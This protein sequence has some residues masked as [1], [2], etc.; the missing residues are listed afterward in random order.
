MPE[1]NESG[2]KDDE[3]KGESKTKRKSARGDKTLSSSD[4]S[5]YAP[6][7]VVTVVEIAASQLATIGFAYVGSGVSF[8]VYLAYL[9]VR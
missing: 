2:K 5:V 7:M 6:I 3:E 1:A 8:S 4:K 9:H